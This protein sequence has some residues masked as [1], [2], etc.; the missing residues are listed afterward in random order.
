MGEHLEN[1]AEQ[2]LIKL[3]YVLGD[4]AILNLPD[5]TSKP[6][7]DQIISAIKDLSHVAP[8]FNFNEEVELEIE[9]SPPQKRISH[10]I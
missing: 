7:I 2:A 3:I 5:E 6:I 4:L 9:N 1:V 10:L 8:H